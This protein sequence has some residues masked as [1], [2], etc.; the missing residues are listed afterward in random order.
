MAVHSAEY[1]GDK[2]RICGLYR[3]HSERD[4]SPG[5]S[6]A[7]LTQALGL[8][9]ACLRRCGSAAESLVQL[10]CTSSTVAIAAP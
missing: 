10:Y 1:S 7:E 9:W 8:A 5:S 6:H 4:D 3:P 2:P